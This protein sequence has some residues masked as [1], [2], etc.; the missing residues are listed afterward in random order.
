MAT[1]ISHSAAETERLGE[2][3]ARHARPGSLIGLV[4]DL[5]AGKTQFAKGFARGLGVTEPILS[6]TFALIHQYTS[7]RL[8]LYHIDFYRLNSS[9]QIRAAGL[10]EFFGSDGVTVVEWWD[11]WEG[12]P[13]PGLWE[14]TFD[15]LNETK[16][17]ITY[18]DPGS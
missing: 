4:G 6:P 10:D 14:F 2:R 12:R 15:P 1:F 9:E 11:R 5:G 17:R 8:P 13:P 3:M 7:G 18:D 16:R